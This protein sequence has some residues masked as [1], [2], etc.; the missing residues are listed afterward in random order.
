MA[1]LEVLGGG[2]GILG[3][4]TAGVIWAVR[5]VAKEYSDLPEKVNEMR[6]SLAMMVDTTQEIKEK[7]EEVGGTLSAMTQILQKLLGLQDKQAE[8]AKE[9]RERFLTKQEEQDR[10]SGEAHREQ[11]LAFGDLTKTLSDLSTHVQ[12]EAARAQA[13]KP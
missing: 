8:E 11:T 4:V 2:A 10:R 6:G 3:L 5:R 1:D 7:T 12:V 13:R 9:D